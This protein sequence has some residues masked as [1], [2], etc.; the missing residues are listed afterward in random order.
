MFVLLHFSASPPFSMAAGVC[1]VCD[2]CPRSETQ[3]E[4]QTAGARAADGRVT[5]CSTPTTLIAWLAVWNG[6]ARALRMFLMALLTALKEVRSRH[7]SDW[8]G[9]ACF[10]GL[11][12]LVAWRTPR[13]AIAL[14][15]ALVHEL[16]VAVTFLLRRPARSRLRGLGPQLAGYGG[17]FL[18]LL[19]IVVA[20]HWKPQWLRLTAGADLTVIAFL[21]WAAGAVLSF[22]SLWYLRRSFSVVPQAREPVFRGPYRL[23][24]HPIYLA[25]ILQYGAIVLTHLSLPF[26]LA[27]LLWLG[28][29]Y[30]RIH[31]EE[32]VLLAASSDYGT[33][34]RSVAMFGIR[35]HRYVRVPAIAEAN[36]RGL[37][38]GPECY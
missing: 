9:F 15:P 13:F 11:A 26:L 23:A 17:T 16:C 22:V 34:C 3:R 32:K 12:G 19:F 31:Y 4:E 21:V 7:W 24:R 14:L 35:L 18:M 29:I 5:R 20:A 25:Y 30:A 2:T 6:W 28:L 38:G 37:R 27:F 33:Y 10:F 8:T 36:H 1:R